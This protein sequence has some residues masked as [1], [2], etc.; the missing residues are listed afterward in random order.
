M[1]R[2][3][4]YPLEFRRQMVELV[5]VGRS[6][7]KL[8]REFGVSS[9]A[10]RNWVQRERERGEVGELEG[11]TQ[12][13]RQEFAALRRE[14]RQLREEREILVK[15]AAWFARGQDSKPGSSNT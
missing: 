4:S 11:W 8:E 12:A 7:E 2:G 15:A 6:P 9:Q 14:V 1:A 5:G 10:I 13:D 3:R